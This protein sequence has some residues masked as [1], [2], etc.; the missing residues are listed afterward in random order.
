MVDVRTLDE[1]AAG[2]QLTEKQKDERLIKWAIRHVSGMGG[3]STVHY[4]GFGVIEDVEEWAV[5]LSLLPQIEKELLDS[6]E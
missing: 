6:L 2:T 3:P 1:V 4:N 5:P